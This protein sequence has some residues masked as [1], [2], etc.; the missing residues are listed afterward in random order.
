MSAAT[1]AHA[2]VHDSPGIERRPARRPIEPGTHLWDEI[3]LITFSFGSGAAFLLQTMDPTIAAVVDEH[4]T[5]RTDAVGRAVRSIASVMTW[6]YGGDEAIAE[7]ERLRAMH[8]TLNSTDANGT[9]HTALS[10]VPWAWVLHTGIYSMIESS[11]YFSRQPLTPEERQTAYEEAKQLMR[12][13]R[14]IEREIPET[15]VEFV[16]HVERTIDE[17]LIPSD[18]AYDFLKVSRIIPPPP[19]L[20]RAAHPIWRVVAAPFGRVQHFVT[21]GTTPEAARAKLGLEWTAKDEAALR[22]LG[23]TIARVVPLL[24][25][26]L[27]YF[28][29]AYEARRV[30]RAQQRLRRVLQHRPVS[31]T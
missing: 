5:F 21:V 18:V 15:Y 28:P 16:Q 4:S 12:N 19:E 27:R 20:P 17:R 7:A 8:A 1:T 23:W 13:F 14:V 2:D 3:G 22:A 10:A 29:I 31:S 9:R 6:I 25:E 11:N 24:P 30:D 26:R